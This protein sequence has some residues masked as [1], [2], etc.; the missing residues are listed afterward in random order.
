MPMPN[1]SLP[2]AQFPIL[3]Q[4][5]KQKAKKIH[6]YLLLKRALTHKKIIDIHSKVYSHNE[7]G[8]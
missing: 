1:S 8:Y 5:S 2:N 3:C 6:I 4:P 7:Y